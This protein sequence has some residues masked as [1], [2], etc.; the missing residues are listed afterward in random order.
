MQFFMLKRM[1]VFSCPQVVY[2]VKN[3]WISKFRPVIFGGCLDDLGIKNRRI[4]FIFGMCI[5]E[6]GLHNIW[7]S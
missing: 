6:T 2:N 7:C 5:E 4:V 3:K 1:V